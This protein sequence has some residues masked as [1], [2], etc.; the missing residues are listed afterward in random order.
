[1][2]LDILILA[3][4]ALSILLGLK[5]GF[6][7]TVIG[8]FGGIAALA[9]AYIFC[10]RLALYLSGTSWGESISAAVGK[11][12]SGL[13]ITQL[14][15][16]IPLL[17]GLGENLRDAAAQ[18]LAPVIANALLT[19]ISFALIYAIA[20]ILFKIVEIIISIFTNLPVIKSFDRLLGIVAG[21]LRGLLWAYLIIMIVAAIVPVAPTLGEQ[22]NTSA[23][24]RLMN[25]LRGI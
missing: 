8:F 18:G 4:L 19:V 24:I 5:K 3:V 14:L 2:I 11:G 25:N 1:M 6:V 21:A 17:G 13:D 10:G 22:I 23:A 7:K 20:I 12:L 16:D 9:L 15:S